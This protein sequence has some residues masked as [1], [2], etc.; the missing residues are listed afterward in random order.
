MGEEPLQAYWPLIVFA[1]LILAG[2]ALLIILSFFSGEKHREKETGEIYESGMPV[3][4]DARIRFSA[5]F[6]LIAMYFVIFDVE[7]LFIIAWALVFKETGWPGYWGMSIFILILLVVVL[8]EWKTGA[9]DFGPK[10]NKILE[11]YHKLNKKGRSD[12][13]EV[14][15]I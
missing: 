3:T 13:R 15:G 11:A 6:Y 14:E 12:G 9:L 1:V 2:N 7:A 10:G 5:D 8:Y 4:G